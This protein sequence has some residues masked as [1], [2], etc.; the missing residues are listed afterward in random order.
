MLLE[1]LANCDPISHLRRYC[2]PR[3]IEKATCFL[4]RI[5][6]EYGSHF[7][8][9]QGVIVFWRLKDREFGCRADCATG[10]TPGLFLDQQGLAL[11]EAKFWHGGR[12]FAEAP[13]K[14]MSGVVVM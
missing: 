14:M 7:G 3:N 8:N 2:T 1:L 4:L 13:D 6:E 9:I 11:H 10:N 12:C 5:A